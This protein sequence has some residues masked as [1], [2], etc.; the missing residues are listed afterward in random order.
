MRRL[1]ADIGG[2]HARFALSDGSGGGDVRDVVVMA[3]A[4]HAGPAEAARAYLGDRTVEEAV[5]AV[6]LPVAADRVKLT[7]ADW[8]FSIRDVQEELGLTRF[9][10]INDFV[11]Q[12]LAVPQVDR[13][14]LREVKAG[15][16][17]PVGPKAVLGP[18]TGLGVAG[19]L[20][21]RSGGWRPVASEGGHVSF[22]PGDEEEIA[23]LR[24]LRDRHGHVSCERLVS[25][26]G[27]VAIAAAYAV[28][29]DRA[30]DLTDPAAITQRAR[31]GDCPVC[32]AA[33]RR[34]V[35]VLGSVAG[36][37]ALMF[38]ATGGVYIGGGIAPKLGDLLDRATFEA[39]FTGKGRLGAMLRP[40]PVRLVLHTEPGLLG[41]ASY[42]FE[43]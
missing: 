10:V 34:F 21:A 13:S 42:R 20:P 29:Q 39:R 26:P 43:A 30:F 7:N 27:L 3:V 33:V 2:T 35:A 1:I 8:D 23:I 38:C 18:G 14:E 25:G 40:I 41:T 5:F 15:D 17:D 12:A 24:L 6:A 36:D 11:A 37:V 16:A 9:A 19:L 32:V 4:D 28:L 31:D 22:A